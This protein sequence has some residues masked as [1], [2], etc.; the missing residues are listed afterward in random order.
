MSFSRET[1]GLLLGTI[2]VIIFGVTLPMTRIAVI[3]L[4]PWFVTSGRAMLAG[5]VAAVV[6]TV[7]G[8]KRPRGRAFYT[9]LIG[10]VF[11]IIGF[12]GF[13]GFAM[14]LVPASHGGVVLGILPLAVAMFAAVTSGER[15][16]RGFWISA[17]VGAALV[18]GFSLRDGD[19]SFGLGNF[20]L[21]DGLL[22]GSVVSAAAGYTA[23]ARLT[24]TRPGWEV[25]SWAVVIGLPLTIPIAVLTAPADFYAVPVAHWAAFAYLGLMSQYIGFF[26]WNVGLA[27]GGQ[28]RVSQTQLLQTF[29]TLGCA[30]LI[31][32]ERVDWL[33]WAFAVAVVGVV[34]M[35]RKTQIGRKAA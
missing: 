25:I 29:V 6:L 16:S 14:R 33:T 23:F 13:T 12:P 8:K 28:A 20:G 35:G 5:L 34:L 11:T 3:S 24:K 4:D 31:N 27:M 21:G 7:T 17:M 10:A 1:L 26:F 9:L 15:P 19:G 30:A 22:V 18:V 2:G 32:G